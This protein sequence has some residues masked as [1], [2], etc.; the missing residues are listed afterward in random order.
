MSRRV[1]VDVTIRLVVDAEEDV[2]IKDLIC[3]MDYSVRSNT[4]GAEI[5]DTRIEDY[6]VIDSK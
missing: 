1:Y 4:N 5:L 2:E 3:E 6:E